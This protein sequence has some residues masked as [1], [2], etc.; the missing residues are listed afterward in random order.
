MIKRRKGLTISIA[1]IMAL[2]MGT[3]LSAQANNH[4]D[5]LLT[6]N[7]KNTMLRTDYRSKLDY[8]S[9][10]MK[11]NSMSVKGASFTGHVFGANKYGGNRYD[12]SGGHF[13][14]FYSGTGTYMTN[15]VKE[16]GYSYAGII[17]SPNNGYAYKSSV[18]WS[19]D[20]I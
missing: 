19:P 14:T 7:F 2:S 17:A 20:S 1:M 16:K 3:L 10:W 9:S 15:M 5:S 12:A 4:N 13:Y 6:F 18:A 8:S 11:C